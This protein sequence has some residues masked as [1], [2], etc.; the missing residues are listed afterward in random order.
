M[1][2]WRQS[3]AKEEREKLLE[4]SP[5][6]C[7]EPM[8][9]TLTDDR[10]SDPD[11]IF[12]RK[13]DGERC[14][15]FRNGDELRL[16]SRNQQTLNVPYPELVEAL[17]GTERQK[18]VV[19]GEIVAFEGNITSFSRLQERMHVEDRQ[20]ALDS[21][22][23]VTFYLFD[24][25][26]L[27]GYDTTQ[28][29][30]RR[31]KSLLKRAFSYADPLRYVAHRNEEGKNYFEVACRRGWEG[32]IGKDARSPYVH[33]R[34]KKWLKFK[35]V[36]QQE[37][38][39][40]GYTEPQGERICFGALLLGVYEG[41]VLRY[42]GKVGTGFD[43]SSL[44]RLYHRLEPL[45]RETPPFEGQELPQQGVHWVT[46]KLVAEIGFEEWTEDGR[47]RQPRYLGLRRDKAPYKV[48]REA[49]S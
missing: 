4:K 49:S 32:I 34:S 30:L 12:E 7:V 25:L 39:V 2:E 33:G 35:C 14:L 11:W 17:A 20:E 26:Y 36:R 10:F 42:T 13:L 44:R 41:D 47:L 19:D 38:V 22:V 6:A 16:L 21:S 46:P 5:P 24:L 23:A 27:D 28:I 43:E 45:E 1:D 18:F 48:V 37:F 15:A 29:P 9:A 3:L 8:L 31:R 40:G